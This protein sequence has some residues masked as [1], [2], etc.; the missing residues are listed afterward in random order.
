MPENLK[1][2]CLEC[3]DTGVLPDTVYYTFCD[4]YGQR[5]CTCLAGDQAFKEWCKG[6]AVQNALKQKRQAEVKKSLEFS[7]IPQR[8]RE[9]TMESLEGYER[10]KQKINLYLDNFKE[11][12]KA[13]RGIY[14]WKS[15]D[16]E[17]KTTQLLT[18]LCR[19]LINRFVAPCIFMTEKDILRK[20]RESFRNSETSEYECIRQ[21]RTIPCLF[22]DGLGL[23]RTTPWRTEI[24]GDILDYRFDNALPTFFSSRY[25]P[26]NCRFSDSCPYSEEIIYRINEMCRN[27]I[28]GIPESGKEVSLTPKSPKMTTI[29][30]PGGT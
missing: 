7:N 2:Y 27:F 19:E 30:P 15:H 18:L 14:L 26:E 8:W 4:L 12:R 20:I 28:I 9:T 29:F 21:F 3:M 6:K 16:L 11:Y 1:N 10:V 5:Y 24:M 17:K 22:I 25:D 13:G 23:S